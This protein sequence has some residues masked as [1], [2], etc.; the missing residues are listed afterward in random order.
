MLG[1]SMKMRTIG[2]T[3]KHLVGQVDISE[4]TKGVVRPI[5]VNE[6]I[7]GFAML[8]GSGT[9]KPIYISP[10]HQIDAVSSLAVLQRCLLGRRLPEPIYWADRISRDAT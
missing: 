7:A 8:P 6:E 10:G 1:V 9:M 4:L 3:K 2:V 5:T